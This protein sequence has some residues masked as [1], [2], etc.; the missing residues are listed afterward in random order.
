MRYMAKELNFSKC[1]TRI[2]ERYPL[3]F[4]PVSKHLVSFS[5][6][7]FEGGSFRVYLMKYIDVR[8]PVNDS[9]ND[10]LH[11]NFRCYASLNHIH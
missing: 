4:P 10:T 11:R 6:S 9:S 2:F 5:G 1:L 3:I 8:G 7:N